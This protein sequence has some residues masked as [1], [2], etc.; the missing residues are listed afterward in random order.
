MKTLNASTILI[1]LLA[2]AVNAQEADPFAGNYTLSNSAEIVLSH[3]RMPHFL[4]GTNFQVPDHLRQIFD[5]TGFGIENL[6]DEILAGAEIVEPDAVGAERGN[7]IAVADFDGDD[8]DEVAIAYEG[9]DGDLVLLL[10][11]IGE[12]T[13]A[14]S[15]NPTRLTLPGTLTPSLCGSLTKHR[16]RPANVDDDPAMELVLAY[17]ASDGTVRIRVYDIDDQLALTELAAINDQSL[18]ETG[19]ECNSVRFDVAVGDFNGDGIDELVTVRVQASAGPDGWALAFD[20]YEVT[21]TPALVSRAQAV[22]IYDNR[23]WSSPLDLRRIALTAGDMTGDLIDEAFVAFVIKD[24]DSPSFQEYYAF[25]VAS[26][27]GTINVED[28]DTGNPPPG[29]LRGDQ[30]TGGT[31]G[32]Q[33]AEIFDI[34]QDGR[35]EL[36]VMMRNGVRILDADDNLDLTRLT[37]AGRSTRTNSDHVR[38]FA[39][40]DMNAE[41]ALGSE[42]TLD[43][44]ESV[45]DTVNPE[46]A[47]VW[48]YELLTF[49]EIE[50]QPD[51]DPHY[52]E[53]ELAVHELRSV[54]GIVRSRQLAEI[55]LDRRTGRSSVSRRVA[56]ALGDFDRDSVRLGRPRLS[57]RTDIVTPLVVLNAP[58]THF[59]ILSGANCPSG[60]CDINTCYG[61][62]PC[63][64]VATHERLQQ[65]TIDVTTEVNADWSQSVKLSAGLDVSILGLGFKVQER[66]EG[67][68]GSQFSKS[69]RYRRTVSIEDRQT[70]IVDDYIYAL[71]SDYDLWEYPVYADGEIQGWIMAVVPT[72]TQRRWFDSK[73]FSAASHIP[74]HEVGN[75]LSYQSLS[76]PDENNTFAEGVRFQTGD[77]RTL[78][79]FGTS[80]WGLTDDTVNETTTQRTSTIAVEGTQNALQLADEVFGLEEPYLSNDNAV[81]D[82][83]I[84]PS[85]QFAGSESTVEGSYTGTDMSLSKSTVRDQ[86]GLFVD[87]GPVDLGIGNVRYTVTPYAYWAKNGALVLDYAI[88]PEIAP[89]GEPDTFW[90]TFY[91][92][93]ESSPGRPDPA[94]ILPWRYDPEK[95]F[96]LS[97]PAQRERTKDL[98]FVPT[99]PKPGDAVSIVA[100]V[101]NWSLIPTDGP[102]EVE[103]YNGDPAARGELIVSPTG[104]RSVVTTDRFELP[105]AIAPR[106]YGFARIDWTLPNDMTSFYRIYAVVDPDNNQPEI[107]ENNNTGWAVLL[108]DGDPLPLSPLAASILP[109]SRSATVGNPAT[110]FATMI[111]TAAETAVDCALTQ[112]TVV[113]GT[114]FYQTTDPAT[115]LPTGDANTPADIPS[116][117]LQTF[118][119]SFTPSTAFAPADV[120]INFDCANLDEVVPTS[121]VNTL[122]LS[123]SATP[124]P[125]IV[126]LGA[127]PTNDGIPRVV[128]GG[129]AAFATATVNVGS[130]GEITASAN[131]GGSSL[132]LTINVCQTDP[133][134]GTCLP[135]GT[136]TPTV[137]TNIGPNETPTFSVFVNASGTVPLN[138]A[139]NRITVRFRDAQ[140]VLRGSTSVA[141]TTDT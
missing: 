14:W 11:G 17:W 42:E 74:A 26:D 118:V 54:P 57:K 129:A 90:D 108:P 20:V 1:T 31:Y 83:F 63:E 30:S 101:H 56:L 27:L 87:F 43:S 76:N 139:T 80:R 103:F 117:E 97:E 123:S 19:L 127:T 93:T 62:S 141:V 133:A 94:F 85:V 60:R 125:D 79:G 105:S 48:R 71:V 49:T 68:F 67:T 69:N 84:T 95:G 137:T 86:Q 122:V 106:G 18:V 33:A 45:R 7:D 134:A 75:L 61:A 73:S 136:P 40:S 36:F 3:T 51:S 114:F 64:F 99:A 120:Q 5:V 96:P 140:G 9:N 35:G 41:S 91:G 50:A 138:A 24:N 65:R 59:D 131:T 29:Y 77:G 110:A 104:S 32:S 130:A 121:G 47:N 115:N 25:S 66:L 81:I 109:T 23:S 132:P 92:S 28:I 8:F 126:A 88:E 34:N 70:A 100:R 22:S 15:N 116:G 12:T 13:L 4:Q 44:E 55:A 38:P 119:F 102:I 82:G 6:P 21:D 58:P 135:P 128:T 124:T 89:I 111:N 78:G 107:H 52:N 16:I 2:G 112:R 72:I 39:I 113:P 53:I 98:A 46:N 10:S 37:T